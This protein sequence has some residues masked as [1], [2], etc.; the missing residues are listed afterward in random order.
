MR[1]RKIELFIE[2]ESS[3]KH[4]IFLHVCKKIVSREF[5]IEDICKNTMPNRWEQ[6][7]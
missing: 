5:N 1:A 7:I 4:N 6:V 2:Y 3:K